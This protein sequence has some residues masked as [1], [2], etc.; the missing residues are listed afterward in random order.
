MSRAPSRAKSSEVGRRKSSELKASSQ[1]NKQ[2]KVTTIKKQGSKG[3]VAYSCTKIT[4]VVDEHSYDNA[5]KRLV[6]LDMNFRQELNAEMRKLEEQEMAKAKE[7]REKYHDDL[8]SN[9]KQVQEEFHDKISNF[10]NE[11]KSDSNKARTTQTETTIELIEKKRTELEEEI[12]KFQEELERDSEEYKKKREADMEE[13]I[14]RVREKCA[15]D[16]EDYLVRQRNTKSKLMIQLEQRMN[17]E[18]ENQKKVSEIGQSANNAK[19]L[20]HSKAISNLHIEMG[21][22]MSHLRAKFEAEQMKMLTDNKETFIKLIEETRKR[23]EESYY[24]ERNELTKTITEYEMNLKN[25]LELDEVEIERRLHT[26][27][28]LLKMLAMTDTHMI[29][30]EEFISSR[31]HYVIERNKIVTQ[32]SASSIYQARND[33]G[34]ECYCKVSI[35]HNWSV[36]HRADFARHS[37]RLVRYLTANYD[38]APYFSKVYTVLATSS[39]VYTFMQR[40][41]SYLTLDSYLSNRVKQNQD[42]TGL[43]YGEVLNVLNQTTNAICFMENLFISH[44]NLDATNITVVINDDKDLQNCKIVITGLTRPIVYFSVEN[45]QLFQVKCF[46]ADSEN[47]L[48]IEHTPPECFKNIFQPMYIDRYAIGVLA[49]RLLR[50]RSPYYDCGSSPKQIISAKERSPV[51]MKLYSK[52]SA[53]HSKLPALIEKCTEPCPLARLSPDAIQAALKIRG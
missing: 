53:E 7:I 26:K 12:T 21:R 47:L 34:L 10:V 20:Q 31:Y 27:Q 29:T 2:T 24:N 4:I 39:K 42:Y 41:P 50:G 6:E 36:R 9:I 48:F 46:D 32:S 49:Y 28:E 30:D 15:K 22:A 17:V 16:V 35:T 5:R 23:I 25:K 44:A 51:Q 14:A 13:E 37:T 3:N 52:E 43:K 40:L 8:E 38:K 45:D 33:D 19:S 11:W 1:A 18:I